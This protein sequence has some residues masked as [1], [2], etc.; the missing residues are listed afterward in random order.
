MLKRERH[1]L[2]DVKNKK[3]TKKD[4][5]RS[6]LGEMKFTFKYV[7]ENERRIRRIEN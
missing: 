6:G 1:S 5:K 2:L 7:Y 4:E 3:N